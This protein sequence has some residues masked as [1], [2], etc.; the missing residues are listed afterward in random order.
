MLNKS[1]NSYKI[2]QKKIF[3]GGAGLNWTLKVQNRPLNKDHDVRGQVI[4]S[5]STF[6]NLG[7]TDGEKYFVV[8]RLKLVLFQF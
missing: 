4:T 7:L 2:I 6:P 8:A 3:L 5:F 1:Q